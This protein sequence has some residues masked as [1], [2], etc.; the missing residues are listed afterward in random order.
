MKNKLLMC[1]LILSTILEMFVPTLN[2]S[3]KTFDD[4]LYIDENYQWWVATMGFSG[5]KFTAQQEK[6][7]RRRSDGKPVY[8]YYNSQK[9]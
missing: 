5:K 3:A 6:M 2:V 1:L 8:G 9:K 7:I 4:E